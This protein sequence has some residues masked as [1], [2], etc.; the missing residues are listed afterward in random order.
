[1]R[2]DNYFT[3]EPQYSDPFGDL[4]ATKRLIAQELAAAA[5]W[6][7]AM[8]FCGAFGNLCRLEREFTTEEIVIAEDV[9]SVWVGETEVSA[10]LE[11]DIDGL[12]AALAT[13]VSEYLSG[14]TSRAT[15]D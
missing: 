7:G 13:V 4:V 8:P 5:T 12:V 6:R 11:I 2:K 9:N 1:M 15:N 3:H 14:D 10:H